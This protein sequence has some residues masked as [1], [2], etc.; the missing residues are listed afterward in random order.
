MNKRRVEDDVLYVAMKRFVTLLKQT[1][2]DVE[3][4]PLWRKSFDLYPTASL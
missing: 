4:W 1:Y 2:L 3:D